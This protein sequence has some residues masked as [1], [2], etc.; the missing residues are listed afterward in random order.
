MRPSRKLFLPLLF[1][2]ASIAISFS[3]ESLVNFVDPITVTVYTANSCTG[4]I[5]IGNV[6]GGTGGYQYQWY[7]QTST[8]PATYELLLGETAQTIDVNGYSVPGV[9]KLRITDSGDNFI[10]PEYPIS[11]P[12]PL[13]GTT[14]F[15][16]LV[17]SDDPNS[18]TLILRFTNGLSPYDWTLTPTSGSGSPR[19]GRVTGINLIVNSLTIGTYNLT[20]TDLFGCTGQKEIII[21]SAT[22]IVPQISTTNVTCPG[23][24]DGHRS[25]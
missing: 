14:I 24:S 12:Y 2:I 25:D 7:R 8:N 10:E 15:S 16:G 6:Q 11:E 23:G 22:P 21:G 17:C 19:T 3:F 9:Y 1:F 13:E 5:Q 20:W 4:V 18:G